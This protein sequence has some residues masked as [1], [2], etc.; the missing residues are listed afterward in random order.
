M[1]RFTLLLVGV[2]A[3]T[4]CLGDD[5]GDSLQGAWQLSAGTHQGEPVPI[6][7]THPITMN[8]DGDQIGGTAACNGYGGTF[9]LSGSDFSLTEGLSWT[10]MG[11]MPSEVMTSEQAFLG[12]LAAVDRIAYAGE[13]LTMSG[14]GTELT[15]E[16]LPAVPTADLT[17]TTWLLDGIIEGDAVTSIQGERATLELF[18]DGS[19]IGSTGCRT[20]AGSYV[21]SG[22]E[23]LFTSFSADGDC[24][25]EL[26]EQDNRV[27]SALEGGFRV[28]IDGDRLS[29]W[30]ARDE[31]LIY[32]ADS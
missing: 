5:F 6:L 9:S 29:T 21:I 15:F 18:T 14:P 30:T 7:E 24:S 10:E 19:F 4:A 3:L 28:E 26:V 11:C 27:I 25:P 23:V 8:L 31:G 1:K 17:G 2:F 16:S 13:L 22:A 12:A 32:R 20:I